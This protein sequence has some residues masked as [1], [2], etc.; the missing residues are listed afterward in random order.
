MR[1]S[2]CRE[3]QTWII[4]I[5]LGFPL[6]PKRAKGVPKVTGFLRKML[7]NVLGFAAVGGSLQSE[8][9]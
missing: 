8:I 7:I 9:K 2:Y 1:M 4:D 5:P 3:P 6:K